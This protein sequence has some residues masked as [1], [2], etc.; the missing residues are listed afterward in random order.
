M[1]DQ[2][3]TANEQ[4][5]EVMPQEACEATLRAV[6]YRLRRDYPDAAIVIADWLLGESV[7]DWAAANITQYGQ[8]IHFIKDLRAKFDLSLK[9]AK[10]VADAAIE[11]T[12]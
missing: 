5:L 7:E 8:E 11:K 2:N 4:K 3:S 1:N 6:Y 9:E 10:E 12:S